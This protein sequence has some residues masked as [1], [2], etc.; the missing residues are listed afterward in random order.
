MNWNA[1]VPPHGGRWCCSSRSLT[2]DSDWQGRSPARTT[3]RRRG[4][5]GD[6]QSIGFRKALV[7][8][9]HLM[10][11]AGE[12]IVVEAPAS[13]SDSFVSTVSSPARKAPE[14]P[15]LSRIRNRR[16]V[17]QVHSSIYNAVATIATRAVGADEEEFKPALETGGPS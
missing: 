16:A 17:F 15:H 9:Y 7:L 2:R 13:F 6:V 8:C 14:N 3:T 4:E 11:A 10:A 5:N 1:T 12:V